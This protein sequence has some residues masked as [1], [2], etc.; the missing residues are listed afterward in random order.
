MRRWTTF[1][2]TLA[3]AATGSVAADA[4]VPIKPQRLATLVASIKDAN[5]AEDQADIKTYSDGKL[6]PSDLKACLLQADQMAERQAAFD[7][8]MAATAKQRVTL[9]KLYAEIGAH[10]RSMAGGDTAARIALQDMVELYDVELARIDRLTAR[11]LT[12]QRDELLAEVARF[13]Q[14]CRKR[15]FYH[16]D[17]DDVAKALAAGTP[18]SRAEQSR[19]P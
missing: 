4:H 3:V 14:N 5:P 19:Q 10:K 11:P 1:A 16:A 12:R 15:K 9:D 13:E 18:K 8:D 7:Q 17:L 2:M 6:K